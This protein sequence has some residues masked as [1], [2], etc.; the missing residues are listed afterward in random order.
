MKYET[1]GG[2]VTRGETYAK[3]M[4]HLREIQECCAVMAHL[5]NTEGNAHDSIMVHGWLGMAEM[6][7][8]VQHKITELAIGKLQ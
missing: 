3:L 2:Q 4:D 7:R 1:H 6:F 5:H 8:Q